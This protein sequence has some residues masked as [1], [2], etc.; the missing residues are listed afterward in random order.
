MSHLNLFNLTSK[1]DLERASGDG[2]S[3]PFLPDGDGKV[4]KWEKFITNHLVF[5]GVQ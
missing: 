1:R 4:C 2:E 3:F 5:F